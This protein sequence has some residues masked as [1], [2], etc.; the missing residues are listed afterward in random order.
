MAQQATQAAAVLE[1]QVEAF[2]GRLALPRT[3]AGLTEELAALADA[4]RCVRSM[5]VRSGPPL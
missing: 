1:S 3:L 4:R 5:Q 2:D